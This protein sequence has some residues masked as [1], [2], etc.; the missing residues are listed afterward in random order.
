MRRLATLRH[1]G[2]PETGSEILRVAV[3][4]VV[5]RG[6]E[7]LMLEYPGGLKLPGGRVEPGETDEQALARELA[8]EAGAVVVEVGE[9]LF[10]VVEHAPAREPDVD[11]FTMVS[12]YYACTIEGDLG[13]QDL[14]DY[15]RDLG[16]APVWLPLDVARQRLRTDAA[17]APRWTQRELLVLDSL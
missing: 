12:R 7:L 9:P 13:E 14:E 15:E 8:E 2:A 3:R 16:L 17:G 10:E 6:S 5:R 1:P 11:V 4:G